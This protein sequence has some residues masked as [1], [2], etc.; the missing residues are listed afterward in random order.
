MKNSAFL[1]QK[2]SV[3]LALLPLL[4]LQTAQAQPDT[5]NAPKADNPVNRPVRPNFNNLLPQERAKERTRFQL[6]LL[7]ATTPAVQD[8][9]LAYIESETTARQ[10][11]VEKARGLQVALLGN[12]LPD[13]QVA[14]LLNDY[15]A[16]IEEDKARRETAQTVLK[17]TVD[18]SKM[19]KIEAM[20]TLM[21]VYGQAPPLLPNGMA[22]MGN[23][24]RMLQD[25]Q[26]GVAPGPQ[27]TMPRLNRRRFNTP[28]APP[29]RVGDAP[30]AQA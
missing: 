19:P 3:W 1:L 26:N 22:G 12:A 13:A 15:L 21:G 27:P 18:V 30:N 24:R 9:L 7:G 14:T 29:A 8:T 23:G 2:A 4:G 10:A 17:K 11:L 28:I 6:Q 5:Q 20:L 25:P 16:A